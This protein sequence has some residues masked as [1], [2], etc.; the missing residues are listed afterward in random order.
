MASDRRATVRLALAAAILCSA[1]FAGTAPAQGVRQYQPGEAVD[2][3]EVARILAPAAP[4]FR[5]LKIHDVSAGR[6]DPASQAG[7]VAPRAGG[8][9][10]A[11]ALLVQFQFDS[12][13]ILPQ[14]RPQLDALAAGIRLLPADRRVVIEG[15]TDSVGTEPYNQRLSERRAEAV[16]Q[17]LVQ[18]HGIDSGRLATE[19]FGPYRPLNDQDPRAPENRR[20]QFRGGE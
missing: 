11:L 4:K 12:A 18:F 13:T 17:Y 15:H 2:P 3:A 10:T 20:V 14:A 6:A 7:D 19:G 8:V 5:S 1:A 9:D 16:K